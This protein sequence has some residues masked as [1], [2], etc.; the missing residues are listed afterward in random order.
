MDNTQKFLIDRSSW[1]LGWCLVET[2]RKVVDSIDAVLVRFT[3]IG[4]RLMPRLRMA[5]VLPAVL[6]AHVALLFFLHDT[7]TRKESKNTVRGGPVLLVEIAAADVRIASASISRESMPKQP[8]TEGKRSAAVVGATTTLAGTKRQA[9]VAMSSEELTM[10]QDVVEPSH[11]DDGTIEVLPP[12]QLDRETVRKAI[13]KNQQ[14]M[15]WGRFPSKEG[16]SPAR[17]GSDAALSAGISAA[18]RGDCARGE[19]FGGGL[20]LLSIPFLAA[21]ALR[22][23]CAK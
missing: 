4:R 18:A 10:Y 23:H 2:I 9:P 7:G 15:A 21:E 1:R 12:L 17:L 5:A 19:F 6:G 16:G 13:Q 20:G 22:G 8:T 14:E 3:G 11:A